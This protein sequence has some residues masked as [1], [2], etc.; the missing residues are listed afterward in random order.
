[1]QDDNNHTCR[2]VRLVAVAVSSFSVKSWCR[3]GSDCTRATLG[4]DDPNS[5]RPG[6]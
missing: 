5:Q 3:G 2:T 1:L 4:P 6:D